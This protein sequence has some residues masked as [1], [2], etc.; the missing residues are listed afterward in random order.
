MRYT[1]P[2]LASY[3]HPVPVLNG[4]YQQQGREYA[5]K[6]IS[7]DYSDAVDRVVMDIAGAYPD[8]AKVRSVV[9]TFE[10]DRRARSFTVTDNVTFKLKGAY[11]V[12]ILT[13]GFMEPGKEKGR[14]SRN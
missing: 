14:L 2:L 8:K 1:I 5:A 9:R 10:Y 12:P 4:C 11:S 3:G 6:V 7:T 13:P